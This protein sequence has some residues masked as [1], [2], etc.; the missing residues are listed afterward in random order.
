MGCSPQSSDRVR[1][2]ICELT[3]D[4]ALAGKG[5]LTLGSRLLGLACSRIDATA[6]RI[7]LNAPEGT[8][9]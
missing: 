7:L 8:A 9:P 3:C 5:A 6:A 4:P 1:D 2:G